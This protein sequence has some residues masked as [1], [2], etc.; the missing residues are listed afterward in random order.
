MNKKILLTVEQFSIE[1][2]K[3]YCKNRNISVNQFILNAICSK[4]ESDGEHFFYVNFN[5][6]YES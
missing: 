6:D 5:D 1:Q 4:L 3:E 2:L